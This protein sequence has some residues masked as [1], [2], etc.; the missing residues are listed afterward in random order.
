M[1]IL[2]YLLQNMKALT[3]KRSLSVEINS[4]RRSP[5]KCVYFIIISDLEKIFFDDIFYKREAIK[6][7]KKKIWWLLNPFQHIEAFWRLCAADN[8]WKHCGKGRNRSFIMM[9]NFSICHNA[10]QLYLIII[11]SLTEIFHT[12]VSYV[13]GFVVCGKGLIS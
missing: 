7:Q 12:N 4:T 3:K 9:S 6:S 2:S 5:D 13:C 11:L 1:R 10:F 8:F